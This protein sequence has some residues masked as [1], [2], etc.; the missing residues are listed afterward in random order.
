M[1][2]TGIELL[3]LI[4]AEQRAAGEFTP[5]PASSDAILRLRNRA[6]DEIGIELPEDYC[7]F[8]ARQDGLDFNGTVVYSAIKREMGS[9]GGI[10]NFLEINS[11]FGHTQ[12]KRIIL[13]GETGDALF[14]NDLV[15][16]RWCSL[17]RASL[18]TIE[19]FQSFNH[20][21]SYILQQAYSF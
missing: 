20:L 13:Y 21:F 7:S 18:S 11:A 10:P 14:A 16:G 19:N 4:R 6:H 5:P 3:D 2:S 12:Q 1:S 15:L 17:D 9:Q 8:L